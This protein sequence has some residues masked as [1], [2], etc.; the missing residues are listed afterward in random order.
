[1]P[2]Q[3]YDLI[4]DG[5][6]QDHLLA[7][8]RKYHGLIRGASEEQLRFEPEVETRNRKPLKRPTVFGGRWE[9]RFGPDN[10][11]RVYYRVDS[12]A[13]EVYVLAIGVK[14]RNRLYVGGEVIEL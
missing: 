9:L 14:R 8:E 4:Y 2:E 11:F 10:R 3:P 12:R 6:V 1:M 13:K 7:I 5:E